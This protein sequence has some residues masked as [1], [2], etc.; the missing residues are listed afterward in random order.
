MVAHREFELL[1][2]RIESAL[3]PAGTVIKSPDYVRDN[4]T[5]EQR[6]V[7]ASIRYAVGSANILIT[8]ECRDR[9]RVEDVTWIEQLA[10]KQKQ[11][12]AAHTIAVSSKGFSVPAL[13]AAKLHGI[14]TRRI[15]EVTDADILAWADTLEVDEIET[16]CVLGRMSLTYD[17]VYPGA[18]LD[19]PS[20]QLWNDQAWDAAIFVDRARDT[21]SSLNDLISRAVRDK[22]QPLQKARD[23]ITLTIPPK[24]SVSVLSD[25]LAVLARDA[26]TDGSTIQRTYWLEIT[27]EQIAVG[28]SYGMLKCAE[29]R[30]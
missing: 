30:L 19:A 1:V 18:H 14:S 7:D 13:K 20:E 6:E 9:T 21:R 4:F 23:S 28:T 5:G 8:V 3:A 29:D 22:G 2:T 10:T 17:G 11:I 25:P 15:D 26:P 24:A 27:E 12:G 16:N